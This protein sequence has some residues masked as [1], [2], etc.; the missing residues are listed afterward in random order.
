MKNS[1]GCGLRLAAEDAAGGPP[2][3]EQ[4]DALIDLVDALE[5]RLAALTTAQE[6]SDKVFVAL[7]GCDDSTVF[8]LSVTESE[9]ELLE[10]VERISVHLG[11]GCKPSLEVMTALGKYDVLDG[12]GD[13]VA[14][15]SINEGE[16]DGEASEA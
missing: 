1:T 15:R 8:T 9:R 6:A 16:S 10:K 14:A 2:S 7:Y 3:A 13:E 5:A 4:V 12:D 11:G